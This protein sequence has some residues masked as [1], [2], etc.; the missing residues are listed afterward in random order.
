M[1]AFNT[2]DQEGRGFLDFENIDL[3]MR[4]C[5]KVLSDDEILAFIRIAGT[6]EIGRIAYS[7][8][9]NIVSPGKRTTLN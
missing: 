3:F 7:Q 6:P 1:E 9:A 5:N 8:F 4:S 2:I